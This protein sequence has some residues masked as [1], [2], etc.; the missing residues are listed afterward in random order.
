ME[1][2]R[3]WRGRTKPNLPNSFTIPEIIK[4]IRFK[5]CSLKEH[6]TAQVTRTIIG[7]ILDLSC[8]YALERIHKCRAIKTVCVSLAGCLPAPRHCTSLPT[9]QAIAFLNHDRA[10]TR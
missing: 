9:L 1:P 4:M 6:F 5:L 8:G 7:F 10:R 2:N 3:T